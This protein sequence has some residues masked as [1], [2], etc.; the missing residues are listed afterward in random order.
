MGKT[1]ISGTTLLCHNCGEKHVLTY[2]IP[3]TEFVA[4][5][6]AFDRLHKTCI[7]KMTYENPRT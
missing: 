6:K 7:K 3:L 5:L 4:K 1:T 2:P